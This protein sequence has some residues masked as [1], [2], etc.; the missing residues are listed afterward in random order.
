MASDRVYIYFLIPDESLNPKEK[1]R[2]LHRTV[3]GFD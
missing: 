3:T 2:D 1:F